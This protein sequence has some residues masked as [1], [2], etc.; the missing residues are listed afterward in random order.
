MRTPL[1]GLWKPLRFEDYGSCCASRITETVAD[2]LIHT[3]SALHGL[4]KLATSR[5]VAKDRV[6]CSGEFAIVARSS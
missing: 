3:D 4:Y 6:D 5:C 2:R 1:R